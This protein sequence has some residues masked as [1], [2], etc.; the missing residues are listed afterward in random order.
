MNKGHVY[1][2][3]AGPGNEGLITKR[4]YDLLRAAEVLVYD[5]LVGSNLLLNVS[6]SCEMIYVGKKSA[7]HTMQQEDINTL[8][9]EKAKENKIVVRLKGGDP[10]VFGRGGEE[11][12]ELN[13]HAV[14]FEVVPGISSSIGGLCYAGIPITHRGYASSFHII[15]GHFK[16]EETEHDWQALARLKGT[17]VFLMGMSNLE[18]ICRQLVEEGKDSS[19]PVAIV[20]WA[21]HPKQVVVEGS[22][23][24]IVAKVRAAG[25]GS[26]SLIVVGEV[27]GLR[28]E[29]NFFDKTPL[30]GVNVAVTRATDQSSSLVEKI[31][32]QGGNPI[33]LPMIKIKKLSPLKEIEACFDRL[34]TYDYIVFTSINGIKRFFEEL[35]AHNKDARAL[36]G[37][38]LVCIGKPTQAALKARG[39][40]ADLVPDRYVAEGLLE[41]LKPHLKA[42]DKILIPR[43]KHAR[44]LLVQALAD[45]CQVDELKL[46]ETI[47][48]PSLQGASVLDTIDAITFTSASTVRYFVEA[49]KDKL[50]TL[51]AKKL[52]SI[53]PITSQ[54]MTKHGL[55]ISSQA[56]HHTIEGMV[57]SL[58]KLYGG[59]NA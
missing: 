37:A 9:V 14:P 24:D 46:Y 21:S 41:T 59:N 56:D 36:H 30:H 13:K 7:D 25:V 15:T 31:R 58:C 55:E 51:K 54:E 2:V 40:L 17:L 32:A 45:I 47:A 8:L 3:G 49:Y 29:L 10:Y 57:E 5:R 42:K 52:I 12:I 26:P 23:K 48:N 16:D 11:I 33:A 1:L 20:H 27:V 35:E 4:G 18:K 53:G 19:T 43:A 28:S 34:G 6:E 50:P 38:K 22:L 44:P 39:I